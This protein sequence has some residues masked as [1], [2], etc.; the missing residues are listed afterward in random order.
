MEIFYIIWQTQL[1]EWV[2][3]DKQHFCGTKQS[4]HTQIDSFHLETQRSK[5]A[6]K[7]DCSNCEDRVQGYN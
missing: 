4:V 5:P 6:W 2:Q 1:T 3:S 7:E